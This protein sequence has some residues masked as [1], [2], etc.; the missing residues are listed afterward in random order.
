MRRF[1]FRRSAEMKL[2]VT[3]KWAR[4]DVQVEELVRTGRDHVELVE[5]ALSVWRAVDGG[6]DHRVR[7]WQCR[8]CPFAGACGG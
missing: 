8:T 3:L 1:A 6:A 7:G 2:L 5:T 4:P